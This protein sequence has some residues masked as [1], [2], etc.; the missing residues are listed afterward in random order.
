MSKSVFKQEY[1]DE[2]ESG[3]LSRKA[4]DSPFMIAGTVKY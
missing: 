1:D 3:K 2:S 4:K